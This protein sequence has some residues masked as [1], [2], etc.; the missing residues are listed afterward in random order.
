MKT[1]DLIAKLVSGNEILMVRKESGR[2]KGTVAVLQ[3]T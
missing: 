1:G 2:D 3:P